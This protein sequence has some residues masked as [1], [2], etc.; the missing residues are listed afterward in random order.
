MSRVLAVWNVLHTRGLRSTAAIT[1][2]SVADLMRDRRL[3]LD[4]TTWASLE[5]LEVS[6]PNKGHGEMY[7]PTLSWPLRHVLR[8]LALPAGTVLV[9]L[10]CGK[11]NVL[12]V[13]AE[14]GLCARGVE[15]APALCTIA[16][17][18]AARWQVLHPQAAPIEVIE[19]DVV[20]YA[21]QADER[22][23]FLFNPFDA[24]V[25]QQV[26]DRLHRSL[27]TQPR[28]VTLVYRNA[29]HAAVLDA[30]PG[31]ARAGQIVSWGLD[32][33]VYQAAEAAQP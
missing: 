24:T 3:G 5:T 28:P 19:G 33:V 30:H 15:F 9:D 16:R 1:L 7:Q 10:G 2:A 32:F 12:L 22:V 26:A 27:L 4:T 17:A 31:F 11:G 23:Y 13:A 20:N 18:N 21:F 29:A 6:G 14:L 25:L 8:R